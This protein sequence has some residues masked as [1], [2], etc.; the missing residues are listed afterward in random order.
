[1]GCF[2]FFMY[3]FILRIKLIV[4][5]NENQISE[6]RIDGSVLF[7]KLKKLNRLEKFRLNHAR[8][9]LYDTKRNVDNLH[10]QWQNL[11]YETHHLR[12]EITKCLSFK[13]VI[14]NNRC[15]MITSGCFPQ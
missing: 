10:L 13:S 7:V 8:E 12:K 9:K 1:M 2:I 6:Q 4:L 11:L 15:F 5:Q 3:Y 14:I